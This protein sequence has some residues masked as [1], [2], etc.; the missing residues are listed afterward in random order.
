[1]SEL[2]EARES[3]KLYGFEFREFDSRRV[4]PDAK[5]F[6][7]KQLWQ[8]SHEIIALALQGYK[9]TE[10]AKILNIHHQTVS[11][12]LNS[13]LAMEKLAEMREKRDEG[14]VNVNKE[15]ARLSKVAL[16]VYK[17]IFENPNV[18]RKLKFEAANTVLMDLGGHRA[19]TKI[20]SQSVHTTAT[21]KEIEDFK[22]RGLLA[23]KESGLMITLDE[24]SE[25]KSSQGYANDSIDNDETIDANESEEI[26]DAIIE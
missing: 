2:A 23:A 11:N 16:D 9:Q 12:T 8:R 6:T 22:R 21:I 24:S 19:P 10:I 14:I 5:S 13:P 1:M 7:I 18:D 3:D 20:Q 17:E 4:D 15:V 25:T 26:Y